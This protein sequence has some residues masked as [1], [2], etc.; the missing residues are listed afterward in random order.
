[1]IASGGKNLTIAR[2][3]LL[4]R[5]FKKQLCT[6]FQSGISKRRETTAV[7]YRGCFVVQ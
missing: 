4:Y 3:T 1:M 2:I 7:A 6:L 5:M